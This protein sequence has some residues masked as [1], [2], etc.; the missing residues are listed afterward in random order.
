MP[1]RGSVTPVLANALIASTHSTRVRERRG[2]RL[3][4]FATEGKLLCL[5]TGDGGALVFCWRVSGY[6]LRSVRNILA[7]Q[8]QEPNSQIARPS[9][10]HKNT[11]TRVRT[12]CNAPAAANSPTQPQRTSTAAT[13]R[14]ATCYAQFVIRLFYPK[15]LLVSAS[16]SAFVALVASVASF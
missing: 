3:L 7:P 10:S 13:L 4:R 16:A 15:T 5:P 12:E 6:L 8:R 2:L 1:L 14:G 11:S 9:A